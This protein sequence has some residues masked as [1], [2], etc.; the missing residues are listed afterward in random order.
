[1][2]DA[3]L[4]GLASVFHPGAMYLLLI[5]TAIGYIIGFIPGLAGAFALAMLIP[6]TF[7]MEPGNAV[8]LLLAAHAVVMT[9]GS[10]SAILFN[11]PGHVDR[12]CRQ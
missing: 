11:T 12:M 10:Y 2:F 4:S 1:M 5:G 9:G 8:V 7:S 3:W 6:F